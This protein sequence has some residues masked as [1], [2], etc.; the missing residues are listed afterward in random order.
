MRSWREC[1]WEGLKGRKEGRNDVSLSQLKHINQIKSN[2]NC[3][4]KGPHSAFL[5]RFLSFQSFLESEAWCRIACV[6]LT[7]LPPPVLFC[8]L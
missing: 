4:E 5:N 2:K 8:L 3:E 6:H 7:G 1:N